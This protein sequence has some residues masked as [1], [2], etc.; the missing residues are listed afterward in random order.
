MLFQCYQCVAWSILTDNFLSNNTKGV[1]NPDGP[2]GEIR[3]PKY[4]CVVLHKVTST[5]PAQ[6]VNGTN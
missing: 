5:A 4:L 3:G 6:Q 2:D 1:L